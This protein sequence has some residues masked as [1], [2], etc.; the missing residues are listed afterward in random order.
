MRHTRYGW[1]K[2]NGYTSMYCKTVI[3]GGYYIFAILAVYAKS[4]KI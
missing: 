3:F 4:A 1:L 2:V